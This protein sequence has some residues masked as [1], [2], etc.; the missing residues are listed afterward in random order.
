[1]RMI[2]APS[3]TVRGPNRPRRGRDPAPGRVL[4][5]PSPG[6]KYHPARK[7]PASSS[8][9]PGR[10]ADQ[11]G[12]PEGRPGVLVLI[13]DRDRVE[14]GSHLPRRLVVVVP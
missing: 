10:D 7:R 12:R 2:I 1:M 6:G 14:A 8:F 11:R 5:M 4:P 13:A 3:V 9:I